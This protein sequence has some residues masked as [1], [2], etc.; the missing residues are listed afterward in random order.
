MTAARR[1]TRPDLTAFATASLLAAVLTAILRVAEPFDHGIWLVAYLLLVGFLAQLLLG[2]GQAALLRVA[3]RPPPMPR[4]RAAQLVL[5]NVGVVAVPLGVFVE[6]RV[7]VVLGSLA[8]VA[9]LASF[10]NSVRP[11][12]VPE[13]SSRPWLSRGYA[14]LLGFMVV[15]VLVGT[16]LAWDAPWL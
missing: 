5:W 12:F 6:A 13:L 8:L 14:A 11:A 7:A 3:S 15:S 10:A 9:A 4:A 16:A 1:Q 2:R